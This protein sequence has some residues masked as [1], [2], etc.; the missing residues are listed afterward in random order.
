MWFLLAGFGEGGKI[1]SAEGIGGAIKQATR[2]IFYGVNELIYK[3]IINLY[4]L[5][6]LLCN[7]RLLDSE[8]L[9]ILATRVGYILGIIMVF[10]VIFNF[11]QIVLEPDKSNDKENGATAIIKKSLIVIVMLGVSTYVFDGLYYV[12]RFVIQEQVLY[13]LILPEDK[14]IKTDNFGAVLAAR[15]FGA[16]YTVNE[17][18]ASLDSDAVGD[19]INYRNLLINS[20][21][22]PQK[23]DFSAGTQC[24]LA[25]DTV[26]EIGNNSS[27]I[28]FEGFI[29]D[30]NWLL[31]M[32]VGIAL[33]YLLLMYALKVGVRVIQLTVLQIISPM[34]IISYLS[35]KKDNMFSKWIKI[36]FSTYIDAFIRIAIIYFIIY[37]SAI[38]LDTWE[39]GFNIFWESVGSPSGS[40][41]EVI[42]IA[43]ILA[44]LTF[45]KKAPDLIKEL[46]P[47]GSS[48]L[49]LGASMKDI[50]GVKELT[51]AAAGV[52]VGTAGRVP[53][54]I[55]Q[56][57]H[58]QGVGGKLK[59]GF[60]GLGGLVT[61]G[62]SGLYHG[63]VGG[64][65][66]K[67]EIFSV[68]RA[69][70]QA[71]AKANLARE[72]RILSGGRFWDGLPNA[73]NAAV[74]NVSGY[75]RIEA[76]NSS[77]SAIKAE[78][79]GDDRVKNAQAAYN[80]AM[81]NYLK[82]HHGATAKDFANSTEGDNYNKEIKKA[83][84]ETYR[85]KMTIGGSDEDKGF[86]AKVAMHNRRFGSSYNVKTDWKVINSR[87][88]EVKESFEQQQARKPQ[89]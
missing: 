2:T 81:T 18:M 86:Q 33:A 7:A 25:Y 77:L 87:R 20:I 10:K 35:P 1:A 80:A 68:I 65:G 40:T 22:D 83:Y 56:V 78:L 5:F 85:E 21:A 74:G 26:T 66:A 31:Q 75:E 52:A 62:V 23:L 45:A 6:E 43:M 61:G 73:F 48:K 42:A 64:H 89:K 44:L 79:D 38:L 47:S 49:G 50:V 12:Q 13:K 11:I 51:G 41:R 36:Y 15:T 14:E 76:E 63:G 28:E 39:S 9:S 24:L 59:A 29:M 71:Q 70:Q 53:G 67:G 34:A 84:A 16:F 55:S 57:R 58:A 88:K 27:P 54:L 46:F 17:G 19:C 37:L 60:G 8:Q 72:K 4:Q 32:I 3:V 82:A 69:G 30:Y